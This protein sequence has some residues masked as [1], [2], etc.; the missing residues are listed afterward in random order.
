MSR[1]VLSIV[2]ELLIV[3]GGRIRR[4][5]EIFQVGAE[6]ERIRSYKAWVEI[7]G[8]KTLRLAYDLSPNSLVFDVGG[9][10]GQF[11][12]DIFSRYCCRILV[13]E[14]VSSFAER[15]EERFAHNPNITVYRAGLADENGSKTIFV[16]NDASSIYGSESNLTEQVELVRASHFILDNNLDYINLMKINIEGGEYALLRDLVQSGLVRRIENI[17]VQFHRSFPNA[18]REMRQIQAELSKTH[19]LTYQYPFVW[20]NW[21]LMHEA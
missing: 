8:D 14:P 15:I 6:K 1:N 11:A 13:F 20:E 21:R 5:S 19:C 9:Y 12:S 16:S 10:E 18:D 2:G 17:Q 4:L 3:I 7:N